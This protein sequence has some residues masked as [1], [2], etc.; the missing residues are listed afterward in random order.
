MGLD[1]DH[2]HSE[3]RYGQRYTVG[4]PIDFDH[5]FGTTKDVSERGIRFVT[6]TSCEVGRRIKF[7]LRFLNL[8]VGQAT[9]RIGGTGYVVRVESDGGQSVVAVAVDEYSL[10]NL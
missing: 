7:T 4:L 10:P 5:G 6:T 9:W 3:R 8:R 2:L 1:G